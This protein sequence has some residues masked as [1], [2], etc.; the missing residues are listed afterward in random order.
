M[1]TI[2]MEKEVQARVEFKMNELITGIKNQAGLQWSLA[3]NNMSQKH[4]HYWEAFE[5][6]KRMW[7]KELDMATPYNDM[8]VQKI[9]SIKNEAVDKLMKEL[10]HR[11]L[12]PMEGRDRHH[13]QSLIANI[14]E[15]ALTDA[16]Y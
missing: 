7:K 8:H 1:N 9:R 10:D 14:L 11:V 2:E 3:F 12:R 4:Q 13:I 15:K 5:Q 16:I 6:M